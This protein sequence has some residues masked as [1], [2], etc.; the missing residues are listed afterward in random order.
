MAEVILHAELRELKGKKPGA[1]R[2]EGKIPGIFYIHGE[3]NLTVALPE[4]SLL[5]LIHSSETNLI[6][7]KLSDGTEKRCILKDVQLD[8]VTEKP[9]HVD[10]QG[11][12]ADEKLTLDIPVVII[13]GIPKGVRE[14]GILQHIIHKLKISCLPEHIPQHIA[15]NAEELLINQ[16]VHIKDLK[17]EN[18][19]V[20]DNENNTIIAILPPLVEKVV[21]E[22][23]VE[24]VAEPEVVG[25]GKKAAE[26][27][28]EAAD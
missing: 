8:P 23:A 7:L 28:E 9:V 10:L 3:N 15:I 16:S 17:V 6:N 11:V 5:K 19:V 12:R 24:A 2:R 13:G 27:E 25:K 1:L 22:V 20:L 21:A 18:F 26:G 14:G 4:K